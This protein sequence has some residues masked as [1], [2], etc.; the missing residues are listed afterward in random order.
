M[1]KNKENH[2]S[3]TEKRQ[4]VLEKLRVAST[5]VKQSEES[6]EKRRIAN[7]GFRHSEESKR[8]MSEYA[9]IHPEHHFI[10]GQ[11]SLN[12]NKRLPYEWKQKMSLAKLGI[13]GEKAN[14]WK[15]GVS[16][17]GKQI[18]NSKD[19]RIWRKAVIK[20]DNFRCTKCG[21]CE[22]LQAHHIKSFRDFP[23]LR[24]DINNGKTLCLSCH[25]IVT[26]LERKE[27]FA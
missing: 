4:E 18:R 24:M 1:W 13:R 12:K 14:N 8:K 22:D 21:A 15:G 3:R 10:K 19:Y 20:R 6:N 26:Q 11:K 17:V 23:E 2:W 7:T 9:K 27:T 25:S 16:F 5:G